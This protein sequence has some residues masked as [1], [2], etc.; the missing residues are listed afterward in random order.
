MFHAN[1]TTASTLA[2]PTGSAAQGKTH[3]E[4]PHADHVANLEAR[5]EAMRERFCLLTI[6]SFFFI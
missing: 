3:D 5:P 1:Q 2:R 6:F 4:L